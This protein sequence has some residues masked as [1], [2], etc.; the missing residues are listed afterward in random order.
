M[1]KALWNVYGLICLPPNLSPGSAR[2]TEVWE[3]RLL[4]ARHLGR[5]NHHAH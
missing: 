5:G 2:A 3:K 4:R 1:M